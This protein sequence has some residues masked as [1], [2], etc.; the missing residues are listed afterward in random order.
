[1][2]LACLLLLLGFP[3]ISTDN[4]NLHASL[5]NENGEI[6]LCSKLH[7]CNVKK[8]ENIQIS[9]GQDTS[10]VNSVHNNYYYYN[11]QENNTTNTNVSSSRGLT[12]TDQVNE[13][14]RPF[15]SPV[16][17]VKKKHQDTE[18]VAKMTKTQHCHECSKLMR[19]IY[20]YESLIELDAGYS[21]GWYCSACEIMFDSTNIKPFPMNHC[22]QCEIDYCQIC[23]A[24]MESSTQNCSGKHGLKLVKIQNNNSR[25]KRSEFTCD[26]CK[27]NIPKGKFKYGCE[28]C[29]YD[30]CKKCHEK[31]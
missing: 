1:M 21:E 6:G 10:N 18:K 16:E 31:R 5:N 7:C 26:S 23:I 20:D 9:Q 29:D 11:D 8:T 27:K 2:N 25:N 22:V 17:I 15:L 12:G 28:K 30:L 4:L 3:A 19:Y 13:Q 24:V 14:E